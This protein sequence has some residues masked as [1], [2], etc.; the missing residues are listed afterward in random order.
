M[1]ITTKYEVG[2]KVWV[3][4][5]SRG[6]VCLFDDIISEICIDKK[7]MHYLLEASCNEV[8]E[9]EIILYDEKDKL[10]DKIEQLLQEIH[11]KESEE[12]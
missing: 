8:K 5:D 11:E 7:E 1:I 10:L 4:Y 2:Q 12:N 9:E 3:I 6:E